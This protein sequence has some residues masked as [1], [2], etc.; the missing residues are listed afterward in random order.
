MAEFTFIWLAGT[1]A[2]CNR[3]CPNAQPL[4][5][6]VKALLINKR[7][8]RIAEPVTLECGHLDWHFIHR[9][10]NVDQTWP[11]EPDPNVTIADGYEAYQG[12]YWKA[13]GGPSEY[14]GEVM[15]I[16]LADAKR[17]FEERFKQ[18]QNYDGLALLRAN[19]L[20]IKIHQY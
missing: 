10:D 12:D 14:W 7:V 17:Q 6:N 9:S 8:A 13:T 19:L 16:N 3:G 2:R 15:A 5:R 20:T 18:Q 11:V 1:K 4:D